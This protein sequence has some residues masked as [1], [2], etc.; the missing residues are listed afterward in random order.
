MRGV[1][2]GVGDLLGQW[3]CAVGPRKGLGV[4]DRRGGGMGMPP[5]VILRNE[6]KLFSLV[7]L[8]YQAGQQRFKWGGNP[9]KRVGFV[10]LRFG[11]LEGHFAGCRRGFCTCRRGMVL[12][13]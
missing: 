3:G 7:E 5:I 2:L 4:K 10:W 13:G 1:K 9:R 12:V 6:A 11:V 8:L